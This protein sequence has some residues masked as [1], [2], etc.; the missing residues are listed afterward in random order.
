M[1]LFFSPDILNNQAFLNEEESLHLS[2]VLRLKEGDRVRILDGKGG[3]FEGEVKRVH[4]KQSIV[5]GLNLIENAY[6]RPYWLHIA[7]APTK[8]MDRFEWFLEKAVEIGI[9]EISPILTKRCERDSV[10]LAR[11]EKIVVSA[12]KQSM[13]PRLPKLNEALSFSKFIESP[14]NESCFIAHCEPGNKPYLTV[15][16]INHERSLVLVGPEG[17][18]TPDEIQLARHHSFQEVS[19]GESRLRSETAAVVVCAQI[20]SIW[21][22][23]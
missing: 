20:Q 10:K 3:M 12:M 5:G 23:R 11:M 22:R 18:F 19:L 6:K 4:H 14:R 13:N 16:A 17:D 8:L 7:V 9:D 21:Q 15:S 1:H 2:K